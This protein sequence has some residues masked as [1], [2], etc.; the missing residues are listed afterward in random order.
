MIYNYIYTY[1]Y[2]CMNVFFGSCATGALIPL[3][4]GDQF[5]KPT[6]ESSPVFA[7]KG[8]VGT[9]RVTSHPVWNGP[10]QDTQHFLAVQSTI[11]T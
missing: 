8:E 1:R 2:V 7:I 3:N 9:K 11:A 6:T 5:F 4:L 10:N